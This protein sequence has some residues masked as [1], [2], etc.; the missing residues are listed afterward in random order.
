MPTISTGSFVAVSASPSASSGQWHAKFLLN[1]LSNQPHQLAITGVLTQNNDAGGSVHMAAALYYALHDNVIT[2]AALNTCAF[3]TGTG[4]T[5]LGLCTDSTITNPNPA[6][7]VNMSVSGGSAMNILLQGAVPMVMAN[8]N[9]TSSTTTAPGMT[10][11]NAVVRQIVDVPSTWTGPS[12]YPSDVVLE[13]CI[14]FM[15]NGTA[16]YIDLSVTWFCPNGGTTPITQ[17]T[18][19]P[20]GTGSSSVNL[21]SIA[22]TPLSNSILPVNLAGINYSSLTSTNIPVQVEAIGTSTATYPLNVNITAIESVSLATPALPVTNYNV[23]PVNITQ[24][25]GSFIGSTVPVSYP[26]VPTVKIECTDG[27]SVTSSSP[28]PTTGGGGGGGGAVFNTPQ[29]PLYVVGV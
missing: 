4:L 1:A 24:V 6:N 14:P 16:V 18:D 3:N 23:F 27:T 7:T 5:A 11:T 10:F 13:V 15:A 19:A 22:G 25:D 2:T 29:S 26:A 28:L 8:S 12:G 9:G 17:I 20:T 21:T